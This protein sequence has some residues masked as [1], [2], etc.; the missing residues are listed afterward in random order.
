M[1]TSRLNYI[2]KT[3]KDSHMDEVL[4]FFMVSFGSFLVT[5]AIQKMT[6]I[7]SFAILSI[8]VE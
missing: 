8:S 2:K 1:V 4:E 6:L 3:E 7:G 5:R